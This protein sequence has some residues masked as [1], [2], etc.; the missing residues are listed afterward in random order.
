MAIVVAGPA[1]ADFYKSKAGTNTT[2]LGV[3]LFAF[4]GAQAAS[5]SAAFFF[6]EMLER[7]LQKVSAYEVRTLSSQLKGRVMRETSRKARLKFNKEI[8]AY[9]SR[10]GV[11][12]ILTGTITEVGGSL[13]IE[14]RIR[15]PRASGKD[16]GNRTDT[17]LKKAETVDLKKIITDYDELSSAVRAV[18]FSFLNALAERQRPAHGLNKVTVVCFKVKRSRSS[19]MS[20]IIRH[21]L[22]ND[23]ILY[24]SD[25]SDI[26]TDDRFIIESGRFFS[27]CGR[28]FNELPKTEGL[29][30]LI[31]GEI[32]FD[33]L[34]TN[35]IR[36]KPAIYLLKTR[37]THQ[38]AEVAGDADNYFQLRSDLLDSIG[39]TLDTVIREDG[40]WD[41][42]VLKG[43]VESKSPQ[44][45]FATL[46]VLIDSGQLALAERRAQRLVNDYPSDPVALRLLAKTLR[47]QNKVN[48]AQDILERLV[49]SNDWYDQGVLELAD[50]Y[51]YLGAWKKARERY[52]QTVDRVGEQTPEKRAAKFEGFMGLGEIEMA[53]SR[54][55]VPNNTRRYFQ[56]AAKLIPNNSRPWTALGTY[57]QKQ[58]NFVEAKRHYVKA[59]KLNKEDPFIEDAL[60]DLYTN[61]AFKHIIKGWLYTAVEL[62]RELVKIFEDEN[63]ASARAY[64][65]LGVA[66][67]WIA[68]RELTASKNVNLSKLMGEAIENFTKALEL[69]SVE[70]NQF[71]TF[72][73]ASLNIIELQIVSGKYELAEN[74][75]KALTGDNDVRLRFKTLARYFELVARIL[76]N[77]K[78]SIHLE[79]LLERI[80]LS[81]N[82]RNEG[83][84]PWDFQLISDYVKQ[85]VRLRGK[86]LIDFENATKAVQ[87]YSALN[88]R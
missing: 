45:Q 85:I 33:D 69:L 20:I 64:F 86:K 51:K 25:R 30:A 16:S 50:L 55:S 18:T 52:N 27:S 36:I 59:L 88:I 76:N 71:D 78:Y 19:V 32:D 22:A 58:N 17:T 81:I 40:T 63:R 82:S 62:Y 53:L 26:I 29:F 2:V 14:P 34:P 13:L 6:T 4:E 43:L 3:N 60:V 28:E 74:R 42:S 87:K 5:G 49:E 67:A 68:N 73:H 38:L 7:S 12:A 37:Q 39:S 75:A 9:F 44:V 56:N 41:A 8:D 21:R 84:L 77:T 47:G 11:D 10:A 24:L 83:F 46:R 31:G 1:S 66:H 57:Y 72:E 54:E 79:E 70:R 80:K 48:E 15:W 65:N 35:A 61:R 23:L